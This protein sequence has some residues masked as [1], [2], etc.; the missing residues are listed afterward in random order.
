MKKT[1]LTCIV[2]LFSLCF[3]ACASP[4]VAGTTPEPQPEATATPPQIVTFTDPVLEKMVRAA[5]NKPDGDITIA[6]AEAVKELKL[7]IEWQPQIPPETQIHDISGLEYF[8]NLENLELQFHA[9]TDISPLAGLTKLNSLSLGGNPVANLEPLSGLTNLGFLTLFNCQAQDYSP[10]AKLTGLGGLLLEF[11]TISDAKALSGLT[12][13]WWLS[14]AH[15]QVSDVSPLSSLVKLQQ[16]QLAECPITDYSPLAAIYP[17][18]VEKDFALA[19]SLRDLGFMPIDNAPQVES[20][21]TETMIVQVHHEDWGAQS[22]PDEVNAVII[23]KNHGT[24][25]ELFI[26]YYPNDKNFLI[27]DSKNFRYTYDLKTEAL[28]ME[29]GEDKA[30]AFLQKIYPDAGD[31]VLVAPMADFDQILLDTFGTTANMLFL[32]PREVKVY[33]PYSLLGLGFVEMREDAAYYFEKKDAS[34]FNVEVHN[35]AWGDWEEGGDVLCFLPQGDTNGVVIKYF[36]SEKK[37]LVKADD[38]SGGGAGFFYYPDTKQFE[39]I[40]CSEKNITVEQYFKNI[41]NNPGIEDI[42]MYSAQLMEDCIKNAFGMTIDELYALPSG[43]NSNDMNTTATDT[44][45]SDMPA[46]DA[47]GQGWTYDAESQTLTI[48]SDAAMTAYQPD[49]DVAE[50]A[51]KTNAPWAEYLPWIKSIV[52]QDNVTRISDY[53]FAY[54]SALNSVTVGTKVTSLGYRCFYR[55]GDYS[56]Q[57]EMTVTINCA[58]MPV[59]GEDVLGWTWNNKNLTV[60]VAAN[61]KDWIAAM[62]DH[63]MKIVEKD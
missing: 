1:L 61:L 59:M 37:F 16:L 35:P 47:A 4:A 33:D 8:T 3:A 19:A 57:R 42:H 30:K 54:C 21:K 51:T 52:V 41:Y 50:N 25:Q 53:A 7:G 46:T 49:N 23:V 2:V 56:S 45:K 40:W 9:I 39:D 22:N 36:T 38:K 26:T 58:S 44:P 34:Y 27:R 62:G 6:E 48:I 29:Y 28:K 11:S 15:T 32:L 55:C 31:D 43:Q 13:L 5:M 24:N 20:Y 60:Y 18:L 10:L 17:N 63:E 14:L 12:E